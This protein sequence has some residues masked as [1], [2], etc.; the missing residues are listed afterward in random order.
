MPAVTLFY[1][2]NSA[3]TAQGPLREDD[4]QCRCISSNSR[5]LTDVTRNLERVVPSGPEKKKGG[6]TS[7]DKA[8]TRLRRAHGFVMGFPG[9]STRG[10][11]DKESRSF[12]HSL[13][14]LLR[15]S[16]IQPLRYVC[17]SVIHLFT[18]GTPF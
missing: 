9:L 4:R 3:S 13:F 2:L 12:L 1:I 10:L 18:A 15:T 14:S 16:R 7:H 8:G 11:V 17:S 6:A 5:L